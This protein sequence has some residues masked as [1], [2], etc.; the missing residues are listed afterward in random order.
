MILKG[1]RRL[2]APADLERE[3][4]DLVRAELLSDPER[5]DAAGKDPCEALDSIRVLRL[6]ALLE[7][8]YRV[9]IRDEEITAER[10]AGCA[11]LAE[12]LHRKAAGR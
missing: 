3:I 6:C 7:K 9:E 11:P 5:E 1:K 4:A 2:P 8:R 12:F 10:F